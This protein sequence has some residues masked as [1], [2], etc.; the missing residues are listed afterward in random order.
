MPGEVLGQRLILAH[1]CFDLLHLGHIR[2]LQQART[3]GERLIVS[4]TAD[5]YVRK[6]PGRPRFG[7]NQRAEALKAL[8]CVD[9]VVIT[10]AP[11][12]VDTIKRLRPAVYIKGPDYV[13]SIDPVLARER[14]AVEACGGVLR[15]TSTRKWSSTELLASMSSDAPSPY[16]EYTVGLS[17]V[18]SDPPDAFERVVELGVEAAKLRRRVFFVGNGGSAALASHMAADWQKAARVQALCFNEAASV[19]ALANDVGFESTFTQP[20]RLFGR[21]GDL[22]FAISS[23]G[24]SLNVLN[25]ARVAAAL[26]MAVV[27]LSGFSET[28]PL[29]RIGTYNFYLPSSSYGVVETT[30][31]AICHAILDRVIDALR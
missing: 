3:F 26:D 13:E 10:D 28:N 19:T 29:R 15:F 11:D 24:A 8:S 2:H 21:P 27:T 17:A 23:S 1:G 12:A 4:V 25:A 18:Q 30:H 5:R 16:H 14:E 20:L 7:D 22:F 6:G 31:Q 9:E